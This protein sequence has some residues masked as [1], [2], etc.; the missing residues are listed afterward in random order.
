MASPNDT[1]L[2]RLFCAITKVAFL[3]RALLNTPTPKRTATKTKENEAQQQQSSDESVKPYTEDMCAALESATHS[4][5]YDAS[6]GVA[7]SDNLLAN[8]YN[9][10]HEN[11]NVTGFEVTQLEELL[12]S[13]QNKSLDSIPKLLRWR[14]EHIWNILQSAT[15]SSETVI[16]YE[17]WSWMAT[18]L[19]ALSWCK[20]HVSF[21][22]LPFSVEPSLRTVMNDTINFDTSSL[23]CSLD[24]FGASSGTQR[25]SILKKKRP[26]VG[27]REGS[28]ALGFLLNKTL[29]NRCVIRDFLMVF[30]STCQENVFVNE[31]CRRIVLVGITGGYACAH[32]RLDPDTLMFVVARMHQKNWLMWILDTS[33]GDG[34]NEVPQV[35]G[36]SKRKKR[37]QALNSNAAHQTFMIC[38]IREYLYYCLMDIP[39]IAAQV[40]NTGAFAVLQ[41]SAM[42]M[43]RC[44][45]TMIQNNKQSKWI[46]QMLPLHGIDLP[47]C[48]TR[49]TVAV[50]ALPDEKSQY[51]WRMQA[52]VAEL[53][54]YQFEAYLSCDQ[55]KHIL[56]FVTN[57]PKMDSFNKKV[58]TTPGSITIEEVASVAEDCLTHLIN[59]DNAVDS[60]S[61]KTS[62]LKAVLCKK[63]KFKHEMAAYRKN[64]TTVT[65]IF[66]LI[67]FAYYKQILISNDMHVHSMHSHHEEEQQHRQHHSQSSNGKSSDANHKSVTHQHHQKRQHVTQICVWCN[68]W[69]CLYSD[70]PYKKASPLLGRFI[71]DSKNKLFCAGS[72]GCKNNFST[73]DFSNDSGEFTDEFNE[74]KVNDAKPNTRKFMICKYLPVSRVDMQNIAFVTKQW[75]VR[76]CIACKRPYVREFMVPEMES[77]TCKQCA[78]TLVT[79]LEKKC[80]IC[81]KPFKTKASKAND[82][83][84]FVYDNYSER[85]SFRYIDTCVHCDARMNNIKSWHNM[86]LQNVVT[87][88][89]RIAMPLH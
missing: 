32:T 81:M 79:K 39:S 21:E 33:C 17:L 31:A 61:L 62:Y 58:A 19:R 30:K 82:R 72:D 40:K 15:S 10:L 7:K 70:V 88:S 48:D 37:D 89:S 75:V 83:L 29:P 8:L 26:K 25:C 12:G 38:L 78:K 27:K 4:A 52:I 67:T 46:F 65:A 50:P 43:D 69:Q 36:S 2:Q 86:T 3:R 42:I 49:T 23:I 87:A 80:D 66:N 44:R 9:Y 35:S 28:E 55:I 68:R 22:T 53:E 57:D 60:T 11:S 6:T 16:H 63:T 34:N 41:S 20:Q 59:R 18:N 13:I 51:N 24:F 76:S 71:I 84:H 54:M 1:I 85:H 77:H 73:T 64:N 45:E 14:V 47:Q 56:L 5:Y 74:D